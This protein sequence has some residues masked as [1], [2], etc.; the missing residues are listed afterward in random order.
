MSGQPS[1]YSHEAPVSEERSAAYW[2]ELAESRGQ[3]LHDMTDKWAERRVEFVK[4]KRAMGE[5]LFERKVRERTLTRRIVD[6]ERT[7]LIVWGLIQQP[8]PSESRIAAMF[9][10][11]KHQVSGETAVANTQQ[12]RG[13]YAGAQQE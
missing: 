7:M 4:A 8:G 1:P 3:L 10:Y 6:L 9:P 11:V 2:K 5:K 12:Q 13:G